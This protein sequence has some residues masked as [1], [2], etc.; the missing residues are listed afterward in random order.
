MPANSRFRIAY[1]LLIVCAAARLLL[2]MAALPPYAGLDEVYHVARLAFVRAEHR[3]PTTT[4]ASI[5]PY[6]MASIAAAHEKDAVRRS[7]SQSDKPV[8]S[9]WRV[10]PT[11]ASV[12]AMGEAGDR[13]PGIVAAR[14][15]HVVVD[16]VLNNA[17]V[18]PYVVRN[19]EAQQTSIYYSLAAH[20]VPLRSAIFELR[21]W[22]LL[23]LLFAL[24]TV[25]ATAEIGRRWLGPIGILGGAILVSL[26]TWE[27]LVIR[28]SN[29][30][31]ACMLIAVGIAISVAAPRRP[32]IAAEALTWGLALNAKMYTWPLLIVLPLL[33]RRQKAG[34]V[35]IAAVAAVSLIAIVL[36]FA[37]L[38]TRTSTEV[39][40][41]PGGSPLG[42]V[43]LSQQTGPAHEAGANISEIIR[44]TIAS[45]AWTSGQHNDALRPAAIALYLGPIVIAMIVTMRRENAAPALLALGAFALAQTYNVIVCVLA[46]RAG[47]QVPIGGKEGWY[48]FVLVPIVVPALLL[49]ALSR[50]RLAAWWLVAWDVVIT[51]VA[52]FHD[53]AGM[54]SPAHGSVLFRWGP[55]HLPFTAHLD[56]I[57]VGPFVAWITFIRLIHLAAF[58]SLESILQESTKVKLRLN[59][60][61]TDI[62]HPN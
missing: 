9:D 45:A 2:Q 32:L 33:W 34:K 3:N 37:E 10:R 19:Y 4:E 39:V 49:P 55:L 43:A 41:Y 50:W 30:A 31:F 47:S 44:V 22:R 26:P 8:P 35:R 48:W 27:T 12:P 53:F 58:F 25:L 46:R 36:T 51:E 17:D 54:S 5:P 13:W 62:A 23:S 28:A 42:V 61:N 38:S 20:L 40:Q 11:Y 60:R 16:R 14:G 52:L 24:I 6:L 1:A 18:K 15:G 57:G 29:D 56:R 59:D 21:F 7:D